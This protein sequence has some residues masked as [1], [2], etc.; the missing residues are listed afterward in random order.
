MFEVRKMLNWKAL[1][2]HKEYV[3]EHL[4]LHRVIDL[5]LIFNTIFYKQINYYLN[6]LIHIFYV[7]STFKICPTYRDTLI[8]YCIP[9]TLYICVEEIK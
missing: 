1:E 9:R 6:L 5:N 4:R 8:Y 3:I 7:K 2:M